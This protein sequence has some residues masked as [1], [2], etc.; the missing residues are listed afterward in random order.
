FSAAVEDFNQK[1]TDSPSPQE[2]YANENLGGIVLPPQ[3]FPVPALQLAPLLRYQDALEIEKAA[4]HVIRNTTRYSKA[5][6]MSMTPEESAI[7]LDGYTIGVPPDGLADSSQMIPLL[8][9]VQN[10]I[11]GTFG[12]SLI[13]PF[14]VPPD[15]AEQVGLVDPGVFQDALLA[16]HR[17]AFVPPHSTVALPTRGVL[18]EAV[19]GHCPSAEKIDLTRF[20]NWQDAPADTAPG[21]GMVQL[22]TTTPPLTTGVTAP[23]SLTNLPP[24]INNLI[25]APQPNT[26]LLQAMGQQA[27]SQQDFSPALTGQQQLASI[28][29]NG[30]TVANQ[31][32][33]DALKTSQTASSD[34]LKAM[35]TLVTTAMNVAAG[36]G[37]SAQKPGSTPSTKSGA[38]SGTPSTSGAKSG[39][40]SGASG[41]KSGGAGTQ[42]GGTAQAADS[43][44]PVDSS[45]VADLAPLA[46]LALA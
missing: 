20:W 7:L 22:P 44:A 2:T 29:Q 18:G 34:A 43:S 42:Q 41:A 11:L 9:C 30:Q 1:G 25:T 46:A 37:G 28:M 32:R 27:A 13:M 19:L 35:T 15:V 8:N 5:L 39:D 4:Q 6:W 38:T 36:G 14:N 16:Y 26:G 24:L 3:S 17:E 33:A 45:T 21:I 10:V 40:K 23:N 12:N 31:A